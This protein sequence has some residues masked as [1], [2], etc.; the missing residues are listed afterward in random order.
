MVK[1]RGRYLNWQPSLLTTTPLQREDASALDRF[2]FH[3]C[4]TRRVFS[5]TELELVT[6]LATIR[7]LDHSV[8]TAVAFP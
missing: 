4:P 5:G 1:R 2:N 8:T 3:R 7:Y 6:S